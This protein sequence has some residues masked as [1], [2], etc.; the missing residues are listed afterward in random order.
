MA[1]Y[2]TLSD[3]RHLTRGAVP[4]ELAVFLKGSQREQRH[5]PSGP[6]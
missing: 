5:K 1:L 2:G 6:A 4:G 3:E